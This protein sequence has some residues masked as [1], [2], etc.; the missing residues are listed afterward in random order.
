MWKTCWNML[1]NAV[2]LR[3]VQVLIETVKKYGARRAMSADHAPFHVQNVL[4]LVVDITRR[5]EYIA[6]LVTYF[7]IHPFIIKTLLTVTFF[8]HQLPYFI[9]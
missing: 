9:I 6:T 4:L 2:R 8:V 3:G 1:R 7:L 5:T